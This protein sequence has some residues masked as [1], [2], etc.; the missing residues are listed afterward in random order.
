MRL[1]RR[2]VGYVEQR[3]SVYHPI[4]VLIVPLVYLLGHL[5]HVRGDT[6]DG[7]FDAEQIYLASRQRLMYVNDTENLTRGRT[8]HATRLAEGIARGRLLRQTEEKAPSPCP[9]PR[10]ARSVPTGRVFLDPVTESTTDAH[11]INQP[12][13]CVNVRRRGHTPD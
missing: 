9:D 12:P 5:F 11:P 7:C 10:G 8:T 2:S 1:Q 13:E 3:N 6:L 4:C